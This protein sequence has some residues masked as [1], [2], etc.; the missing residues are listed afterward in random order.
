MNA[1]KHCRPSNASIELA[2][3]IR[4]PVRSARRPTALTDR[5]CGVAN[6][7][8]PSVPESYSMGAN[9]EQ[10]ESAHAEVLGCTNREIL[11]IRKRSLYRC[12]HDRN[13]RMVHAGRLT[14]ANV[15]YGELQESVQDCGLFEHHFAFALGSQTESAPLSDR[16]ATGG[17]HRVC[18]GSFSKQ[19]SGTCE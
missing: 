16:M 1:I 13:E 18:S 15:I 7:I 19:G 8:Q 11:C 4:M 9:I 6:Q 12:R 3:Q 10:P 17:P 5:R 14:L 2:Q